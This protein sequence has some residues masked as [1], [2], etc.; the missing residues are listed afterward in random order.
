M[1]F[2]PESKSHMDC[3]VARLDNQA[4]RAELISNLVN[5]AAKI[6]I[7]RFE[8]LNM[9]KEPYGPFVGR[10][11]PSLPCS[12]GLLRLVLAHHIVTFEEKA[13]NDL[14]QDHFFAVLWV[15]L[16]EVVVAPQ[17]KDQASHLME[18]VN[19]SQYYL[20]LELLVINPIR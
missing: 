10:P 14:E 15:Y 11:A 2:G 16:Q 5:Q 17:L 8:R 9:L 7:E 19:G 3:P 18:R 13:A 6:F 4:L 20:A 1:G 12:F